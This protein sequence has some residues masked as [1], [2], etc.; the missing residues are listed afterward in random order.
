MFSLSR[1][2][3]R[4]LSVCVFA[5]R[6]SFNEQTHATHASNA[7]AFGNVCALLLLP[8]AP[9]QISSPTIFAHKT[10]FQT[11]M[12]AFA[13]TIHRLS[14]STTIFPYEMWSDEKRD[15]RCK[16]IYTKVYA[17]VCVDRRANSGHA[18][19]RSYTMLVNKHSPNARSRAL[20]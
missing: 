1:F 17:F 16:Y 9:E 10:N 18:R 8:V 6:V 14:R 13:C 20:L 4:S 19:T 12:N 5:M 3:S 2:L 11:D 15:R 7:R